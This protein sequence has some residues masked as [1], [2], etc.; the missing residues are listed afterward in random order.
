[1]CGAILPRN[2]ATDEGSTLGRSDLPITPD[3]EPEPTADPYDVVASIKSTRFECLIEASP[4]GWAFERNNNHYTG[5]L[6]LGPGIMRRIDSLSISGF[7][8]YQLSR[9][10]HSTFGVQANLYYRRSPYLGAQIA[11]LIDVYGSPGYM[12]SFSVFA[13][14]IEFQQQYHERWYPT[15]AF[16]LKLTMYFLEMFDEFTYLR[17][18]E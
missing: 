9:T 10:S 7:V 13:F 5:L 3:L 8:T 11:G 18:T 4:I 15:T 6:R 14:S 2:A 12:A 16:Y 1:M 17:R